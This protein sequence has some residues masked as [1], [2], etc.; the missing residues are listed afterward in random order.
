MQCTHPISAGYDSNGE[1]TFSKKLATNEM[2]GF[3][4]PCGKCLACR[5]NRARDKAIRAVHEAKLH[6]NNIFLT[7]TY[8]EEHLKSPKL[9]YLDWQLFMKSLRESITRD[10]SDPDLREKLY[11]PFM[12]TGEYGELHKRPHWHAILFNYW[13]DDATPKYTTDLDHEVYTSE[14]IRALWKKGNIEFGSVTMESAGYVARY[15]AKKL[16]HGKDHEHDL[17]PIHQTSKKRAIGRSWIEKYYQHTFDNGFVVLPNGQTAQIPRY[18][19]DWV[20]KNKPDVFRKYVTGIKLENQKQAERKAREE[21]LDFY[22]TAINSI[23]TGC[24]PI[25][26]SKVKQTIL[27]R[28]FKQLQEKLKL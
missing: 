27:E 9:E 11:I 18:Y 12:V 1:V 8:D 20:K 13:P 24:Y 19:V 23:G 10:I 28:K 17:H 7:L 21:E 3:K 16:V 6:E 2:V 25:T 4:V 26:R 5:L 15:A 22:T 14:K